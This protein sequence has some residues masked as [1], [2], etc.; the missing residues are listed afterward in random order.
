[1]LMTNTVLAHIS[2]Q[3][4]ILHVTSAAIREQDHGAGA[5]S[6]HVTRNRTGAACHEGEFDPRGLVL[7][8][9]NGKPMRAGA[10]VATL[11]WLGVVPS[12]SRPRRLGPVILNPQGVSA[13]VARGR[14]MEWPTVLRLPP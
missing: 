3:V 1:M 7:H 9:D 4:D 13:A 10:L 8:S 6:V 11:Q 14:V 5:H 2:C 12:F